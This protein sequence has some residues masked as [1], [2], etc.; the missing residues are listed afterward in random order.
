MN[1]NAAGFASIQRWLRNSVAGIW[2]ATKKSSNSWSTPLPAVPPPQ[3]SRVSTAAFD[4][5]RDRMPVIAMPHCCGVRDPYLV[6]HRLRSSDAVGAAALVDA[7]AGVVEAAGAVAAAV[8]VGVAGVVGADVGPSVRGVTRPDGAA[9]P[10]V[11]DGAAAGAQPP[12]N[13]ADPAINRLRRLERTT[14][15][16]YPLDGPPA[17]CKSVPMSTPEN[18]E[19]PDAGAVDPKEQMRVALEAK[20]AAQ[21]ASAAAGPHGEGKAGGPQHQQGGKRTFRR[22]AG[23]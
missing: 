16:A 19:Q 5:V 2:R 23:G 22:K 21:H 12:R 1:P 20:K 8:S 4:D 13:S 14:T 18:A 9:S 3:A 11:A 15:R 17:G 10:T 6:R 7:D